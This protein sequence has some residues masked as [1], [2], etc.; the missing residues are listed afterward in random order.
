MFSGSPE[1]EERARAFD[2]HADDFE[3][4]FAQSSNGS[5]AR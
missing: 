4:E 1:A 2:D 3:E 5:G